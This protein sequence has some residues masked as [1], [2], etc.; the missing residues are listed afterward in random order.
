[1]Q[2]QNL[3]GI[4]TDA[5]TGEPL[6][7]AS[8]YFDNTSIGTTTDFDGKFSIKLNKPISGLFVVS[9]I[10]YHTKMLTIKNPERLLTLKLEK[11]VNALSEVVLTSSDEWSRA[12][13]LKEFRR[14]FLGYSKFSK[15]CSIINEADI[16]L[17]FDKQSKQLVASSKRPIIIKNKALNYLITYDLHNFYI[18]YA[19]RTEGITDL[20]KVHKKPTTVVYYGTTFFQ[21]IK[22][23]NSRRVDKNR[24][25]AYTGS[26]LHF[27]RSIANNSLLKEKFKIFKGGF[28][29]KPKKYIKVF[30]NDSLN[31][32][33]VELPVKLNIVHQNAQSVIKSEVKRFYINAFGNHYPIDKV[34]FGGFM[35]N[36]R[37][38]SVLPLNY[39]L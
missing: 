21:P 4:V 22:Q 18:T 33:E 32:T 2:A 36:K 19:M 26:V 9:Y 15:S 10:G 31:I 37:M 1:M 7:A 12:F 39:K 30:K 28:L 38:G 34:L 24:G 20:E 14:E 11:N 25:L 29:V 6:F 3:E 5:S 13:K 27:M 35:A 17:N 8:V 16:V 23:K